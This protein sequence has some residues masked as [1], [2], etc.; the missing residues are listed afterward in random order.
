MRLQRR[1]S[2]SRKLLPAVAMIAVAI[3][4]A[5]GL[6]SHNLWGQFACFVIS[7]YLMVELNNS[8]A[9]IRIYSRM[10]S[11]SYI[12][13][14]CMSPFLFHS[15]ATMILSICMV[16]TFIALFITYQDKHSMGWTF[17][18]FTSLGIASVIDVRM[19]FFAPVMWGAMTFY[20]QSMTLRTFIA[21]IFGLLCPYWFLSLYLIYTSDFAPATEH[22][23]KLAT[24]HGIADFSTVPDIFSIVLIILQ[25]QLYTSL[26]I[27]MIIT[28]S[29]LIAHFIALTE[30]KITNWAFMAIVI[31]AF[32]LTL[33]NII[34][35]I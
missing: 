1:I 9:L 15:T 22:F 28:T 11:C 27:A 26:L 16:A 32:S 12:I 35:L 6:F 18:G 34:Q 19:I 2:R 30:T 14:V 24:F 8:N 3:W 25:P 21:S 17:Y 7:T 31:A 13:M 4:A 23:S 33:M 29:P 5:S 10:M 20:L